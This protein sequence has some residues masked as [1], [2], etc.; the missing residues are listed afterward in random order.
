MKYLGI[1]SYYQNSYLHNK[2]L[3]TDAVEAVAFGVV[4]LEVVVEDE[5]ALHVCGHGYA[6]SRRTWN[7]GKSYCCR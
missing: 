2:S 5:R 7:V 1:Y 4:E 6:H 3:E